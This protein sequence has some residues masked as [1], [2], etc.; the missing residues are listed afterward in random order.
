MKIKGSIL[1]VDDDEAVLSTAR[2]FLKQKFEFVQTINHPDL[3][4]AVMRSTTFDLVL[5]DMNYKKGESDGAVG[6]KL[7]NHV[8]RNYPLIDIIAVTAYG[9]VD[10][11]VE[12]LKSGARDFITKPWNNDRLLATI[13]RLMVSSTNTKQDQNDD[14]AIIGQSPKLQHVLDVVK[15][16][17]PTDANVLILGDNGTGKDL[18]AQRI[19]DQ[20]NRKNKPFIKVDLGALVVSIFESELFGHKKGAFTDAIEDRIG[21]IVLADGGTLFLDEIGNISLSQQAKLLTVLESKTVTKVGSNEPQDIDIR[22]IS[23]TNANIEHLIEEGHFRQDF[24]YRINTIEIRLPAL[25]ERKEDIRFLAKHFLKTYKHKY[26]KLYLKI[27]EEA[28]ALLIDHD[29]PG[30]IRELSHVLE[31]TVIMAEKALISPADIHVSG[32][33]NED[34]KDNL[35]LDAMEKRLILKSLKKNKGNIT[36]AAKDLGIDRQVLYRRLEKH[37]L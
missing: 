4:D 6:L 24:L 35:N 5:L 14:D 33:I 9:D 28:I 36:H 1:I 8:L 2:L 20:S 10:L 7:I 19:H 29:W 15:K 30:N 12:A 32:Q 26:K 16:V 27:S 23:A 37:G 11:A 21:K 13:N 18:L 17:A 3:F 34:D 25:A 31:K 22:I